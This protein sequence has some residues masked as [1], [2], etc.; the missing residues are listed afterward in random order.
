MGK[1]TARGW[2]MMKQQPFWRDVLNFGSYAKYDLKY[3]LR[4]F[5]W[6]Y[7]I[8]LLSF[9][10]GLISFLVSGISDLQRPGVPRILM[11]VGWA[12]TVVTLFRQWVKNKEKKTLYAEAIKDIYKDVTPPKLP[13]S[14]REKCSP[15]RRRI[16]R[17][18][19]DGRLAEETTIYSNDTIDE[20]LYEGAGGVQMERDRTYEKELNK[21]IKEHYNEDYKPFLRHNYRVS[22]FYGRQFQNEKKWGISGEFYPDSRS[23]KVHKTCYF[24]TYLTNIIPGTQLLSTRY[25]T[26]AVSIDTPELFLP[27]AQPGQDQKQLQWLGTPVTANELGVTTL[28]FLDEADYIPLWTQNH[29]AQ[30]SRAQLVATGSGS[31]DWKDCEHYLKGSDK[32]FIK[33]V[34][35]G[36]ERELYEESIGGRAVSQEEFLSRTQTEVTGY[37]RWL[38]KGAKSEFV[39][40][41]KTDLERLLDKITPEETEVT[42]GIQVPS[43]TIYALKSKLSEL[44]H[45]DPNDPDG[46]IYISEACS[47]S[48]TAAILALQNLCERRVCDTCPNRENCGNCTVNPCRAL[49]HDRP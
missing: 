8:S 14:Q 3:S 7:L 31:A 26:A 12:I 16:I 44:V 25:E 27:Y 13:G 5:S 24:D 41:S 48:C 35:R 30:S 1:K 33:A 4:N 22:M 46:E 19:R 39:G 37:F 38:A 43:H 10:V 17:V 9:A 28:C 2:D 18:M 29:Q 21:K 47:I 45:P 6:D 32:S 11:I 20:W 36:M 23:V 34:I 40:I 42:K 49:F 15:W